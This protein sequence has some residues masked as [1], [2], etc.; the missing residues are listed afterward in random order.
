MNHLIVRRVTAL[1]YLIDEAVEAACRLVRLCRQPSVQ[2][3]VVSL[4]ELG[5]L[6]GTWLS[7]RGEVTGQSEAAEQH[8]SQKSL[9]RK[10]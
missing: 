8:V 1:V 7:I 6:L 10:D 2:P 3:F 9:L 5:D 4:L